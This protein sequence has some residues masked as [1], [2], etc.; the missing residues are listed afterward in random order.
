MQQ[1]VQQMARLA[2]RLKFDKKSPYTIGEIA[3]LTGLP[4]TEIKQLKDEDK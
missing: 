4:E 1:G 3:D 2:R